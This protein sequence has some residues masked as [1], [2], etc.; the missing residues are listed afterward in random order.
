M[1][2]MFAL[3]FSDFLKLKYD[4]LALGVGLGENIPSALIIRDK[5]VTQVEKL[6]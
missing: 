3:K 2:I 5:M 6:L 4:K 1:V